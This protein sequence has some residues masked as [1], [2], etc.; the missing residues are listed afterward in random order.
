MFD[1]FDKVIGPKTKVVAVAAVLLCL[2]WHGHRT[3]VYAADI[4]NRAAACE[5]VGCVDAV[6]RDFQVSA[7]ARELETKKIGK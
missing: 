3:F 7:V 6:Q 2:G 1:T 4:Y 5:Q